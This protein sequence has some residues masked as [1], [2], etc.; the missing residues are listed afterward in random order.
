MIRRLALRLAWDEDSLDE[1]LQEG[2]LA[3]TEALPRFDPSRGTQLGTF[4]HQR[5]Q[6]RMRHWCRGQRRTLSLMNPLAGHRLTSLDE[7]IEGADDGTM[8][9]HD[10]VAADQD[11][12]AHTAHVG[13]VASF[14]RKALAG[15]AVRQAQVL[16]LRFMDDLS[17]SEIAERL[18]ISRPRVTV[19]V[20]TGMEHLRGD[21]AFLI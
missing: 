5:A 14:V 8:S 20:Q 10:I 9:L 16:R 2:N 13:I 15:L 4:I 6:S 3:L 17:P 18:G 21:L 12:P 19:L 1:L 7:E 11:S